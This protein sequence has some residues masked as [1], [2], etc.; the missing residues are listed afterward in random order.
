MTEQLIIVI[1]I[2]WLVGLTLYTLYLGR[3]MRQV[4]PKIQSDYKDL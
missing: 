2:V 4:N 3:N 1:G